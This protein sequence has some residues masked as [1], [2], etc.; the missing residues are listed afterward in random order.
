VS[1]PSYTTWQCRKLT[2]VI[3]CHGDWKVHLRNPYCWQGKLLTLVNS[4][5]P[6]KPVATC[7]SPGWRLCGK[8]VKDLTPDFEELLYSKAVIIRQWSEAN[9]CKTMIIIQRHYLEEWFVLS[10][11]QAG[12]TPS[13]PYSYRYEDRTQSGTKDWAWSYQ[14]TACEKCKFLGPN[15]DLLNQRLWEWGPAI[16]F[17]I[18]PPGNSET[19]SNSRTLVLWICLHLFSFISFILP[20]MIKIICHGPQH[21]VLRIKWACKG[22]W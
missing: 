14:L 10:V 5:F 6:K 13:I 12:I 3:Q 15:P 11:V 19:C 21:W 2:Q 22:T 7:G 17:F 18:S 1:S 20:K 8:W 16:C 9:D 4:I